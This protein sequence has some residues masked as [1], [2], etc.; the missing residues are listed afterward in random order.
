MPTTPQKPQ[1]P[2]KQTHTS[3]DLPGSSDAP[4]TQQEIPFA[5][6][7]PQ[8]DK[9]SY[10]STGLMTGIAVS[11]ILLNVAMLLLPRLPM[12]IGMHDL[13]I[14][15]L[16]QQQKE[17]LQ[18]PSP[19]V[20]KEQKPQAAPLIPQIPS[21]QNEPQEPAEEG[22]GILLMHPDAISEMQDLLKMRLYIDSDSLSNNFSQRSLM[23]L[24]LS[25]FELDYLTQCLHTDLKLRKESLKNLEV[26]RSSS[27]DKSFANALVN[28]RQNLKTG[29]SELKNLESYVNGTD[30][31]LAIPR[32]YPRERMQHLQ[33]FARELKLK[34]EAFSALWD[35]VEHPQDDKLARAKELNDESYQHDIQALKELDALSSTER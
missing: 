33:A 16:L 28:Q 17:Q 25:D 2:R 26:L 30:Q 14:E 32:D 4:Q 24:G 15:K 6:T 18:S 10:I 11:F 23:S 13:E 29:L 31:G 1:D 22:S 5:E 9:R 12:H 7:E 20:Q 8:Q 21:P 35:I 19:Q 3:P 27:S 34:W